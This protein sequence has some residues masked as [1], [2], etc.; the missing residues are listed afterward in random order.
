MFINIL[1]HLWTLEPLSRTHFDFQETTVFF[2]DSFRRH[3]GF[4]VNLKP[5]SKVGTLTTLLLPHRLIPNNVLGSNKPPTHNYRQNGAK[6]ALSGDIQKI[7][8]F[9][10]KEYTVKIIES[11]KTFLLI[12]LEI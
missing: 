7:A 9:G 12:E 11:K 10:D 2:G 4:S 1:T 5:K 6:I 3:Y 8:L